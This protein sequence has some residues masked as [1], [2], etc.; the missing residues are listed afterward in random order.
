VDAEMER[1]T[2]KADEGKEAAE[3]DSYAGNFLCSFVK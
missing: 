1:N 2:I 3:E